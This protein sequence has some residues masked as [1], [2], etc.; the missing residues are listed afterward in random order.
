MNVERDERRI[1]ELTAELE[2]ARLARDNAQRRTVGD[3]RVV[4]QLQVDLAT[5]RAAREQ[6]EELRLSYW[7][8]MQL[9]KQR[10][11]QAEH[12][13]DMARTAREQA[14]DMRNHWCNEYAN[15]QNQLATAAEQRDTAL[16][17]AKEHHANWKHA[18]QLLL[19]M[20]DERDTALARVKELEAASVAVI[21]RSESRALAA[22]TALASARNLTRWE[23]TVVEPQPEDDGPLYDGF[24]TDDEG[25]WIRYEDLSAL[26]TSHPAPV[27][28]PCS[29][30]ASARE[31]LRTADDTPQDLL[32]SA[33]RMLVRAWLK[34]HPCATAR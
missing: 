24:L 17:L 12:E 27:A 20:R 14:E 8:E 34:E 30:C 26:L 22:E 7:K 10:A 31:L 25:T 21:A 1:E 33:W 28:A 15:S 6:A 11:E 32:T 16:A 23:P 2:R 5:L 13:R 18:Q 4:K 29:G 9:A 3:E 19:E